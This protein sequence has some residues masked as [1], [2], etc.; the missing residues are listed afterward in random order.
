M[1]QYWR[2]LSYNV[3]FLFFVYQLYLWCISVCTKQEKR[4][5][6][7]I[8]YKSRIEY[9][10]EYGE[11]NLY[12]SDRIN[13][14][15][16]YITISHIVKSRPL[17][18]FKVYYR[19]FIYLLLFKAHSNCRYHKLHICKLKSVKFLDRCFFQYNLSKCWKISEKWKEG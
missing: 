8:K 1:L 4:R 11:R 12:C 2:S 14:N 13:N 3:Q 7:R 10:I 18:K 19:N 15:K 16:N 6:K 17:T 9:E 5:Y